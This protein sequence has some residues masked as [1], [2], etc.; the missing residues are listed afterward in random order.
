MLSLEGRSL[1]SRSIDGRL[2]RVHCSEWLDDG[3]SP[4]GRL[5][6]NSQIAAVAVSGHRS[7][8]LRVCDLD[9]GTRRS[10]P[11]PDESSALSVLAVVERS[12]L[13]HC[14]FGVRT[15]DALTGALR[16]QRSN[17]WRFE[18]PSPLELCAVDQVEATRHE[19]ITLC[20]GAGKR[21]RAA[22]VN[23]ADGRI[24]EEST[25]L[26]DF[27]RWIGAGRVLRPS[28]DGGLELV[29]LQSDSTPQRWLVDAELRDLCWLRGEQWVIVTDRYVCVIDAARGEI[30]AGEAFATRLH[31]TATVQRG[32]G[33][34]AVSTD[35]PDTERVALERRDA[36][37]PV[38]DA[39]D[40]K[41]RVR[42]APGPR[43]R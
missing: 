15:V 16:W 36:R 13:T 14:D 5:H 18:R 40:R 33:W 12:I 10:L 7:R 9:S 35:S 29:S 6:T 28:R 38:L 31:D 27:F 11:L 4:L 42:R 26:D 32:D 20:Y 19:Y 43:E 25:N 37:L 8:Q 41:R 1:V 21:A 3:E 23:P 17:V 34:L 24:T 39:T 30:I 2:V 22:R